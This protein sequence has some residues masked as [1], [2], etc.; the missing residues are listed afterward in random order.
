MTVGETVVGK[1]QAQNEKA[2]PWRSQ[3]TALS[4]QSQPPSPPLWGRGCDWQL[5]HLQGVFRESLGLNCT[6]IPLRLQSANWSQPESEEKWEEM[7][8]STRRGRVSDSWRGW[9]NFIVTFRE[10]KGSHPDQRRPSPPF[11]LRREQL[12]AGLTCSLKNLMGSSSQDG[13]VGRNP[14]LPCTTKRR[15]TTTLKSVNNCMKLR[16]PRN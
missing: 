14:S 12:E 16:Q 6:Y 3:D 13:G 11:P 5:W 4:L 7:E 10:E 15:I 1:L 2:C 9:S 8:P